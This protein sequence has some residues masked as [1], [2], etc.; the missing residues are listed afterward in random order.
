MI[1]YRCS[2]CG[3]I[4]REKDW[5]QQCL[6]CLRP[7]CGDC[8]NSGL[9][10]AHFAEL[11]SEDQQMLRDL[12]PTLGKTK[13]QR[14]IAKILEKKW[15]FPGPAR[16]QIQKF[17]VEIPAPSGSFPESTP[18]S[19]IPPEFLDA[20]AAWKMGQYPLAKEQGDVLIISRAP[21][22][23]ILFLL[24]AGG[25]FIAGGALMINAL[26]RAFLYQFDSTTVLSLIGAPS[27][28]ILS[29]LFW[30][31]PGIKTKALFI[32]HR[33]IMYLKWRVP[34][35][36]SW[37]EIVT[38]GELENGI[39]LYLH[40]GHKLKFGFGFLN[41]TEAWWSPLFMEGKPWLELILKSYKWF[42]GRNQSYQGRMRRVTGHVGSFD[43]GPSWSEL[44]KKFHRSFT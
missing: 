14:A 27:V 35:Y 40:F 16:V 10:P 4:W 22:F 7:L 13:T 20:L 1:H 3:K 38:I 41:L 9:C 30:R 28:V 26:E 32:S 25:F 39:E 31:M 23:F 34:H 44:I 17:A 2:T 36:I 29:I 6:V 21:F 18:P 33:G 19:G 11:P 37:D 24:F 8:N 5:P 43:G 12:F 15:V 42:V